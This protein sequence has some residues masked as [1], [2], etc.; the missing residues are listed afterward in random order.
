M[1]SEILKQTCI[2]RIFYQEQHSDTDNRKKYDADNIQSI[3]KPANW[4][5][6]G[7]EGFVM[8][9]YMPEINDN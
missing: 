2:R 6:V 8:V 3:W 1:A 5:V 9:V 4:C 7:K